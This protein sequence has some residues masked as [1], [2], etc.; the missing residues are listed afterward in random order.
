MK[1]NIRISVVVACVLIAATH[2]VAGPT[3]LHP[4]SGERLWLPVK[5]KNR[6]YFKIES[7]QSATIQARGPGEIKCFVRAVTRAGGPATVGY[8]VTVTEGNHRLKTVQTETV[9]SS[10]KW[11]DR[12]EFATKSRN[13]TLSIPKGDHQLKITFESKDVK[14]AG[15]RYVFH[16]A[17]PRPEQQL[18]QAAGKRESITL[19]VKEKPLDYYVADSQSPV[20]VRVIG[21]T[22]LRVVSRLIC[23]SGARDDQHYTLKLDRDAQPLP[24]KAFVTTKSAVVVCERHP[25]W[26]LGK[27]RTFYVDVA[28]GP[29]V[30]VL[31]PSSG[32]APGVA[33]RF[34][35]PKQDVANGR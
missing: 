19:I 18:L 31:R 30:V 11:K 32:D 27:S 33:L 15:I 5:G 23:P 24:D 13:F 4:A 26:I 25:E 20:E 7:G 34:S 12:D 10:T 28:A 35:I 22:R 8:S 3:L 1:L 29:H 16:E 9:P 14:A 2:S 6:G 17:S 21:P